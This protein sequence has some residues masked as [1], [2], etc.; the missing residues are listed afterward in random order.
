M[1]C[2][3][4]SGS[5]WRVENEI[6][7]TEMWNRKR[8]GMNKALLSRLNRIQLAGLLIGI[9]SLGACVA[10][11]FIDKQQ[12]F[13]SY[14]LGY[15]FWLGLTLGCFSVTMILNLTGARWVYPT[16]RFLQAGF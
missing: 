4:R 12:F 10:G 6:E 15:L 5:N 8:P 16:R 13:I 1:S 14:L 3:S 9:I 11:A 7:G 2:R